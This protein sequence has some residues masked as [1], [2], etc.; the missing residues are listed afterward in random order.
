MELTDS[1]YERIARRLDG[2]PVELDEFERAALDGIVSD[3][4]AA[5]A[6]LGVTDRDAAGAMHLAAQVG[7]EERALADL[8]D[9]EPPRAAID[10]AWRRTQAALARPHRML[11]RLAG[12]AAAVAA[13]AAAVL[14]VSLAAHQPNGGTRGTTMPIVLADP[15]VRVDADA[16]AEP[17]EVAQ[18]PA[19]DLLAAEVDQ[20]EADILAAGPGAPL[21]TPLDLGLDQTE[22]AIEEFWLEEQLIIE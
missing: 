22:R 19:L 20:L 3:E 15:A 4:S 21:E 14:I 17:F 8:L 16:F 11:L 18:D 10:H 5:G 7:A 6:L 13:V 12:S 9:V 2:E 1:Q